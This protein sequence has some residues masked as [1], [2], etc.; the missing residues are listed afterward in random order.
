MIMSLE[1]QMTGNQGWICAGYQRSHGEN[2]VCYITPA[3][4]INDNHRE[5]R[6]RQMMVRAD[7]QPI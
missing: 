1:S 7:R 2:R 4:I 5:D 3:V 6:L